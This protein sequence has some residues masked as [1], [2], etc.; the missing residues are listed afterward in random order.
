MKCGISIAPSMTFKNFLTFSVVVVFLVVATDTFVAD[1][2]DIGAL[3]V[4]PRSI[5]E[6][7]D[8][9][10]VTGDNVSCNIFDFT[11]VIEFVVDS[12]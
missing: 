7:I 8:V 6:S 4:V 9:F 10:G 11:V 5:G 3:E 2:V 1:E 12:L